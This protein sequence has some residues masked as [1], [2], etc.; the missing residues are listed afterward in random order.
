MEQV[1]ENNH[2][3]VLD[4]I[5]ESGSVSSLRRLAPAARRAGPV[6]PGNTVNFVEDRGEKESFIFVRGHSECVPEALEW[7]PSLPG[8]QT[9]TAA[10]GSVDLQM[11]LI[12]GSDISGSVWPLSFSHSLRGNRC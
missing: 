8:A 1:L 5:S 11:V 4:G 7:T 12:F 10:L 3:L 6:G 2:K 9:R